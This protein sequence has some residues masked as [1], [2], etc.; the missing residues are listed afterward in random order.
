MRIRVSHNINM[1]NHMYDIFKIDYD[2]VQN[3]DI[4][5]RFPVGETYTG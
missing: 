1:Y 3:I 4:Y 2:I 5:L